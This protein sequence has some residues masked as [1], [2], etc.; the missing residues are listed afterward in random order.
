MLRYLVT[1]LTIL[2]VLIGLLP[3]LLTLT[4]IPSSVHPI[5]TLM[6]TNWFLGSPANRN[7][8]PLEEISP[9]VYQ[10]VISSEDGQFCSHHG[11]DWAA[12]NLV[13]DDLIEGERPRGA[14]T[15]AMQ[16]MKNLFLWPNR[17]YVRKV[18]EV[19]LA[20][21]A[22]MVW[23][24]PRMME[25]YLNIAEWGPG[26]FGIEAAARHHFKKSAKHLSRRQAA[27]LAVTLPNPIARNP[28]KPGRGMQRLARL[29]QKRAKQSGAYV[30]CLK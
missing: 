6:A 3:F 26:I 22:D 21:F 23:S 24:K 5:S 2:I 4:Y 11:V 25:I 29:V 30:K 8:V 15:I 27:L 17:S 13:V 20:L 12:V 1:R 7:W 10:S 28:R 16:S 9:F 14:S 18:L 19:P